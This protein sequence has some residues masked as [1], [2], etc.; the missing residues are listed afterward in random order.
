MADAHTSALV[1]AVLRHAPASRRA[2]LFGR[3]LGL[4]GPPVAAPAAAAGVVAH[5][6]AVLQSEC[7]GVL[8]TEAAE[9][10]SSVLA[11]TAAELATPLLRPAV[12]APAPEVAELAQ[13]IAAAAGG[14]DEGRVEVDDAMAL[15]LAA[16]EAQRAADARQL[17]VSTILSIW[18]T[19]AD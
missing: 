12:A 3:L 18:G 8:A 5:Y 13:R 11:R 6:F 14:S 2:R 19:Y 17:E 7:G 10:A 9:G 16:W 1:A 15:V 4:L